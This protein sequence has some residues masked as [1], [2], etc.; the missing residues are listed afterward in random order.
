MPKHYKSERM[1]GGVVDSPSLAN[2]KGGHIPYY[3]KNKVK[4]SYRSAAAKS[5]RRGGK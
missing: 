3:S 1:K 4:N 2:G 5:S